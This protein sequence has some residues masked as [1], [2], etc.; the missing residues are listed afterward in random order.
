[1]EKESGRTKLQRLYEKNSV[2]LFN[3]FVKKNTTSVVLALNSKAKGI[4]PNT[5]L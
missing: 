5:C 2:S 4:F 3:V 1:M